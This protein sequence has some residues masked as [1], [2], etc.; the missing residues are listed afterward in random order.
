[1]PAEMECPQVPP[2]YRLSKKK[3]RSSVIMVAPALDLSTIAPVKRN[4]EGYR[5]P[6]TWA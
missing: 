5:V 3:Y 2:K 4:A 6:R 1:M